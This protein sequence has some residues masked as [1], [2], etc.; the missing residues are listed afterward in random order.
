MLV[1]E[2]T[3]RARR[4]KKQGRGNAYER[5]Q[6]RQLWEMHPNCH[7][8]Q[9]PTILPPKYS[10]QFRQG[11]VKPNFA[12]VEHLD[13]RLS[14]ERGKHPG[15]FRRVIACWKCNNERNDRE[16][17][18]LPRQ[19]LWERSRQ[20]YAIAKHSGALNEVDGWK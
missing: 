17:R 14:H 5:W 19:T 13:S 16:Q 6:R 11:Q 2:R 18:A 9:K 7:W 8:C 10:D 12:T 20:I 1:A 4:L 15:E 3:Q